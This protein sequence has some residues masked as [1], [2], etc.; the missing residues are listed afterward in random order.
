M[1]NNMLWCY[2]AITLVVFCIW[3]SLFLRDRTTPK[4]HLISW[5]ILL[6]APWFWPIVLPLSIGELTAKARKRKKR[7][8]RIKLERPLSNLQANEL[9]INW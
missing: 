4:N 8:D 9:N 1:F 6:I 5:I 7:Q 2:L 3:L